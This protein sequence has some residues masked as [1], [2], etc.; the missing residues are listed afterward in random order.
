MSK[1]FDCNEIAQ[2]AFE[3]GA[4]MGGVAAGTVGAAAGLFVGNFSAI[5]RA[6]IGAISGA[7]A[8]VG[9][10]VYN[11]VKKEDYSAK[12]VLVNAGVGGAVGLG[13]GAAIGAIEPLVALPVIG[14]TIGYTY[15]GMVT[16]KIGSSVSYGICQIYNIDYAGALEK[17]KSMTSK[18]II[19]DSGAVEFG[20]QETPTMPA[21]IKMQTRGNRF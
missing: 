7:V 11:T 16:G 15:G 12:E 4:F 19:N 5:P 1:K 9:Y 3:Q 21:N 6:T 8:G 10:G 14:A 20:S 2:K 17:L 13:A 18:N